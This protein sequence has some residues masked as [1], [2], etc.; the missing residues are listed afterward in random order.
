M[1][2]FSTACPRNCYSTCSFKVHVMDGKIAN[3]EPH[4]GN[5]A[6]PK[7]VC[8]KG[9]S[10]FERA[11]SSQRILHPLRKNTSGTFERISWDEA[12]ETISRQMHRLK[13]QFGA[14][15]IL[16]YESSG[17]AGLVNEFSGKFWQLFGGATTTYGNLCWPAGLEGVRLT[18]GENKHNAPWDIANA[19]LIILWGKNPAET[20]VQQMIFL[21]EAQAKGA[22]IVVVDPRRTQSSEIADVLIQPRPG[23]DAIIALAIARQ[24]FEKG[25]I[26]HDFLTEHVLGFEEFRTSLADVTLEKAAQIAGVPVEVLAQLAEDIGGIKPMTIVPGYGMQ[27][28]SNGGQTIRALLA[29]NV[30]TGNIGKPGACF[31][32]ANLQSYVFDDVKEPLCYYPPKGPN[33][34]FRR[35][36]SKAKLGED[37]LR[38]KDPALKMI[39]VE[40]G[41]PVAQNPDTNLTLEAFRKLDFRVVVEQF[42]TDTALE[43]DIVLP[44]KNMFEQSDIIGSYWNPYVQLK[45]KILEPAGEVK[46]ET[47]IY[48]ELA[49][50]LGFSSAEI[51][52]HLPEPGD[53]SIQA[54]L[55]ERLRAF[56]GLRWEDLQQGPVLAPG[57]EEIAFSDLK[58]ATLSG[59]IELVSGE[60]S[61]IWGADPLPTYIAI[62]EG[63]AGDQSRFP[64]LLLSPN[65]QNRIHSQFGN[66]DLIKQFAPHPTI[67]MSA[68]DAAERNI[69]EGEL[70]RVYNDR[71]EMKVRVRLD[72][73]IRRGCAAYYNGWW[74]SEGGTPNLFTEGRET[75]MGHGS[76]FHDT[77]I[78]IEKAT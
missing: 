75:D 57:V 69:R 24:L 1:P 31:H 49:R 65:T 21:D 43:A 28:F 35:T 30:L 22:K 9:L 71:G 44:A 36:I 40:R 20:N 64:L 3:F 50:K 5:R 67:S 68:A 74:L 66:L 39:W 53:E 58:F 48:Y 72:F 51:A 6:T 37:M 4:P 41:N 62:I 10:Y 59:K 16:F 60:A 8:L 13:E 33:G 42:M 17:M 11:T 45:P 7:G 34:L 70:V 18:L 77:R 61:T 56:P 78:E 76:A 15:S 63:D 29:L 73:S 47:E 54:F 12:L 38:T 26:D 25:K 52:R 14:K 46:P 2:I 32:Y 55:N 19:R 27:R 23:T